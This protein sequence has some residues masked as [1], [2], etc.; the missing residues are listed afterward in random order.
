VVLAPAVLGAS[1]AKIVEALTIV[2]ASRVTRRWRSAIEGTIAVAVLLAAH[3]IAI[4]VPLARLVLI[5]TLRVSSSLCCSLW[6][7]LAPK[8]GASTERAL[9][10]GGR[11]RD[12][13]ENGD[14][15]LRGAARC[16]RQ[17]PLSTRLSCPS[18]RSGYRWQTGVWPRRRPGGRRPPA[19]PHSLWGSV[20]RSGKVL[21]TR[22]GSRARW[23]PVASLKCPNRASP[24]F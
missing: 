15:S 2:A 5:D 7:R 17:C 23:L 11:G 21:S 14:G 6:A 4:G 3:V 13:R 9:G 8:A 18:G 12:L 24:T 20:L 19:R 16:R 1:A 10:V 22:P